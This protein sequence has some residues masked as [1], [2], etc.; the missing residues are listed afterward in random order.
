MYQDWLKFQSERKRARA[1]ALRDA[2]R[3]REENLELL[4]TFAWWMVG[5][6]LVFPAFIFFGL[7]LFKVI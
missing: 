3:Q 2:N 1:K 5:T 7:K 4:M 6:L